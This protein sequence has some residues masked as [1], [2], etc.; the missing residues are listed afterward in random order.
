MAVRLTQDVSHSE[1]YYVCNITYGTWVWMC[2]G[3]DGVYGSKSINNAHAFSDI[4]SVDD[5]IMI[6][7]FGKCR[8]LTHEEFVILSVLRS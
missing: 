8:I 7:G 4:K 3:E 6:Y 2:L 1:F 5:V